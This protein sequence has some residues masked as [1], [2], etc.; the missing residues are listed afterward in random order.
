MNAKLVIIGN[1]GVGKTCLIDRLTRDE[2]KLDVTPTVG[3]NMVN[4]DVS[5]SAGEVHFAIWDTA[6]QEEY[7]SMVPMYFKDSHAIMIVYDLTNRASFDAVNDWVELIRKS[8]SSQPNK[9]VL[10]TLVANKMDLEDQ[11][12][13]SIDDGRSLSEALGCLIFQETSAKTGQGITDI[14]EELASNEKLSRIINEVEEEKRKLANQDSNKSKLV[15]PNSEQINQKTQPQQQ[16]QQ[17]KETPQSS[18]TSVLKESIS[19]PPSTPQPVR[20][21]CKCILL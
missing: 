16:Q 4:H 12:Q 14:L 6:G 21:R 17:Q 13:V 10:L 20:K 19:P 7:R 5:T 2:F 18:N 11:R 15:Q 8:T 9:N 3:G 1:S